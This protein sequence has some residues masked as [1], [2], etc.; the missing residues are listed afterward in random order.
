V[1]KALDRT[2]NAVG[3]GLN[4][5]VSGIDANLVALNECVD[6]CCQECETNDAVLEL[7]KAHL[8]ELEKLFD[9]QSIK[10]VELESRMDS[11]MCCCG[12]S[13][14]GKGREVVLVEE[15]TPDVLG[16]PINLRPTI[17]AGSSSPYLVPPVTNE[18]S[19]A[20]VEEAL[21]SP[22]VLMNNEDKENVELPGTGAVIAFNCLGALQG[23][24]MGAWEFVQETLGRGVLP[25]RY[26]ESLLRVFKQFA[27]TLPSG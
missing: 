14:K 18:L 7:Y 6:C 21:V 16:S 24:S 1:V 23:S 8:E 10:L 15:D 2:T 12:S 22:L 3:E 27:H 26:I 17:S 4:M 25:G 13:V 11:W 9:V 20:M 19:S 5:A